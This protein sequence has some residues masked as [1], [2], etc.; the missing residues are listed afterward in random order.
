M[1]S[2]GPEHRIK[3]S[4]KWKKFDSE[5]INLWSLKLNKKWVET[6]KTSNDC[7]IEQT[8]EYIHCGN[9]VMLAAGRTKY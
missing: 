9:N 6:L 8:Y 2:I 7:L 3:E 5:I 1:G 4:I